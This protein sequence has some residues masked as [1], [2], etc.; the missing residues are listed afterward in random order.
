MPCE[1]EATSMRRIETSAIH[2]GS[3]DP[4]SGCW[5]IYPAVLEIYL[6]SPCPNS[7]M[8]SPKKRSKVAKAS[9]DTS[10]DDWLAEQWR[11]ETPQ[12]DPDEPGYQKG[13]PDNVFLFE[14]HDTP[15][16]LAETQKNAQENESW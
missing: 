13:P 10:I 3:H 7:H 1:A 6:K 11:S 2:C 16:T 5:Y 12:L 8:P 14:E 9:Q 15:G 4:L